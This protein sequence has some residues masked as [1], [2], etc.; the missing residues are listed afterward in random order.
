MYYLE[1][2]E[3]SITGSVQI[4]A[5]KPLYFNVIQQII[6]F[7][8]GITLNDLETPDDFMSLYKEWQVNN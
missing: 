6:E 1:V 2:D 7:S 4:E 5:G 8:G 3:L